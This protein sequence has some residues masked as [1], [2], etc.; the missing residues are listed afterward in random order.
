LVCCWRFWCNR[1]LNFYMRTGKQSQWL[2]IVM[3]RCYATRWSRNWTSVEIQQCGSNRMVP[4]LAWREDPWASYEKCFQ[5][6]KS[7]YEVTSR[8]QHVHS[9]SPLVTSFS[10][11]TWKL[12]SIN[13]GRGQQT[14]WKLLS[15]TKSRQY[16]RKWRDEQCGTSEW[17]F[18]CVFGRH[19]F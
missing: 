12:K 8:V 15:N 10:G 19:N 11:G 17:V 2:Q 5:G 13:V 1:P 6:A 18:R 4:P 14:N 7:H 9:I 3:C 16:H